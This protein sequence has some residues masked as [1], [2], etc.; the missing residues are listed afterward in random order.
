MK[1]H[2][3]VDTPN[4]VVPVLRLALPALAEETLVLMVT[5]TDWWLAGHYFQVNGDATKAAMNLMGYTMWLVP[6]LF[7]AIAIGATAIIARKIGENEPREASHVACQAY[8]LGALLAGSLTV[9]CYFWGDLFI[10]LMI[11][12]AEPV[13]FANEYLYI[14]VPVIPFIMCSQI[15]AACLRGAGDTVTGF[16]TKF[17]VVLVNIVVSTGLVTGLG[18]F[19]QIGWQGLAI[20]TAAG[21]T[22][23]GFII[24]LVLIR[25]RA[26]LK[27]RLGDLKPNLSILQRILRIGLPGGFDVLVLLM[28]QLVFISII[29]RL[30]TGAAAAHG[31]AVQIE[32]CC[33]LPGAAFQVA[34]ATLAGQFLGA[35]KP[36]R[37]SR[38]V[39]VA[40]AIGSTI[41]CTMGALLYFFGDDFA[42]FFT[43]DPQDPT[44]TLSAELLRIVA[45]A[46]PSLSVLMILIGALRGAGDTTWPFLFTLMGFLGVRIPLAIWLSFENIEV[47][48]TDWSFEGMGYGVYGAWYAMASDLIFRSFLVSFRFFNGGWKKTK[49]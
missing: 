19:P 17:V 48:W 47:P 7:A 4:N 34:A 13:R 1:S 35:K 39:L 6:S 10:R 30:G 15:G 27:I 11:V 33:Y 38:S 12:D 25:G 23:S 42:L 37:A 9:A 21:Y 8:W 49:I 36:D 31:L 32:A 24:L 16:A 2:S 29:Y 40:T 26:G 5:W 46:T 28:S 43:G 22:V 20:G 3:V 41:I 14:I 44:T 18:G 45:L